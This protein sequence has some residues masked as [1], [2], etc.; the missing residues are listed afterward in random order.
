MILFT[1]SCI[2]ICGGF[3]I[4]TMGIVESNAFLFVCLNMCYKFMEFFNLEIFQTSERSLVII[5]VPA[6]ELFVA[7]VLVFISCELAG[8]ISNNFECICDTISNSN[9]YA[10]PLSIRKILPIILINAQE[11]VYFECFGSIPCNRETFKRVC[12]NNKNIKSS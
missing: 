8:R 6:V 2:T 1:W 12:G 9:W 7:F 11:E 4:I 3:L 10:F 5:V